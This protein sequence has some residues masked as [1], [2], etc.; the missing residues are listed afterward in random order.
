[1]A[2][3]NKIHEINELGFQWKGYDPFLFCMHHK[4]AF[5]KGNNEM[6]PW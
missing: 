5:L 6:E 1:M 4:D 2:E 3:D